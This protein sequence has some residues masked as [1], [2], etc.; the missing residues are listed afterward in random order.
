M[1]PPLTFIEHQRTHRLIPSRH[2]GGALDDLF[3]TDDEAEAIFDLDG[4]TNDRLLAEAGQRA[5]IGPEELVFGVP[6]STVINAAFTH[7]SPFG[8]RF[9]TPDRGA[10]YAGFEFESAL[11]EVTWHHTRWLEEIGV[12]EDEVTKDEWLAEFT[13]E[14][15]DIR[16]QDE[17]E[18]CL[19]PDPN[20]GYPIG[21]DMAGGLLGAGSL[22]LIYAAVR[23]D[24]GTNIACF[25]PALV[26]NVEHGRVVRFVWSGSS[27]PEIV[28]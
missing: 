27:L 22:G 26:N 19:N 7:P 13:G 9:N 5:G 24:G 11:A 18:P 21:Q 10:W 14:F 25:R 16:E 4:A 6:Y 17:F 3:D 2:D 8:G 12:F 28:F 23:N 15:H 1:I 20:T